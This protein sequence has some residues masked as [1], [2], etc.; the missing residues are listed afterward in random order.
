MIKVEGHSN[1]KRDPSN[2]SIVNTDLNSYKEYK[3]KLSRL[4]GQ[5]ERISNIEK[6]LEKIMEILLNNTER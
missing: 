6:K 1:F 4:K 2:N 3:S 5:E